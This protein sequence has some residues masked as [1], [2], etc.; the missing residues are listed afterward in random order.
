ML[1]LLPNLIGIIISLIKCASIYLRLAKKEYRSLECLV[2]NKR[3]SQANDLD[4]NYYS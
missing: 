2:E 1:S 3:E 4:E